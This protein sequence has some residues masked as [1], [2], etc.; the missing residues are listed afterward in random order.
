M[1]ATFGGILHHNASYVCKIARKA[2][3]VKRN[4]ARITRLLSILFRFGNYRTHTIWMKGR[5][6][7][8]RISYPHSLLILAL[9]HSNIITDI[10]KIFR[11]ADRF[12]I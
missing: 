4:M 1:K 3:I 8:I 5:V 9:A 11:D 10:E 6:A 12:P 7:H 2:K